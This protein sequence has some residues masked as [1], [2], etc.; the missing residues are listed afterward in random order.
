MIGSGMTQNDIRESGS[1][2]GTSDRKV[3]Q[4]FNALV[5]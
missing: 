2:P 4:N 1:I 5:F 3:V